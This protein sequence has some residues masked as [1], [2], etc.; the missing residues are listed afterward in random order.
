M[1]E[2]DLFLTFAQ[3]LEREVFPRI[4]WACFKCLH[5]AG[6]TAYAPTTH[7][8]PGSDIDLV[9][10]TTQSGLEGRILS[11]TSGGLEPPPEEA[12]DSLETVFNGTSKRV[13]LH[14]FTPE[15]LEKVIGLDASILNVWRTPK[16]KFQYDWRYPS[17]S[18]K[19]IS[20]KLEVSE[21]ND[22][23]LCRFPLTVVEDGELY[24]G[25]H[26]LELLTYT[27]P[28]VDDDGYFTKHMLKVQE[29]I[30]GQIRDFDEALALPFTQFWPRHDGVAMAILRMRA[31]VGKLRS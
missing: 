23:L 12:I 28:I 19:F 9:G 2:F 5:I 14:T 27:I 17:I 26:P 10:V 18:G 4:D 3:V 30:L 16:E 8:L 29:K 6:T 22:A 25:P 21:F 11:F 13:S 24:Y 1:S 15:A 20:R 31:T 7:L